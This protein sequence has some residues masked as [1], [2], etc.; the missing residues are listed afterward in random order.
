MTTK[1]PTHEFAPIPQSSALEITQ[2]SK[3]PQPPAPPALVEEDVS[4]LWQYCIHD[5]HS[6]ASFWELLLPISVVIYYLSS[7]YCIIAMIH[8]QPPARLLDTQRFS[9]KNVIYLAKYFFTIFLLIQAECECFDG[10]KMLSFADG[11]PKRILFFGFMQYFTGC[12]VEIISFSLIT[13]NFPTI[14]LK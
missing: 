12:V 6:R 4:S 3:D 8:D 1:E 2:D 5:K 9:N 7:F 10:W 11:H 13:S 14:H